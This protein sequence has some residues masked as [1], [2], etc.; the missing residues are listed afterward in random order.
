LLAVADMVSWSLLNEGKYKEAITACSTALGITE[1]MLGPESPEM[2][3]CMFNLAT[4]Y[5]NLGDI[6]PRSEALFQNAL[7]IFENHE[8]RPYHKIGNVLSSLGTLHFERA[9]YDRAEKYFIAVKNL[10]DRQLFTTVEVAPALKNLAGM[11]WRQGRLQEAKMIYLNALDI[12]VND[13]N[14]GP[15]H[16]RCVELRKFINAVA[17]ESRSQ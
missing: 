16:S 7:R 13:E 2:G 3:T 10:Y 1:R 15:Q 4:A 5:L 11:Y 14:H 8:P 12:L 17:E 6:G 9:E